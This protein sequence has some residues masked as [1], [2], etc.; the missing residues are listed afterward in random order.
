MSLSFA[1][2]TPISDVELADVSSTVTPGQRTLSF[3]I[4]TDAATGDLQGPL[5]GSNQREAFHPVPSLGG[6]SRHAPPAAASAKVYIPFHPINDMHLI[7]IV[8]A[9]NEQLAAQGE[10]IAQLKTEKASSEEQITEVQDLRM[11]VQNLSEQLASQTGVNDQLKAE[12]ASHAGAFERLDADNASH[13][14]MIK[15]LKA[16][17]STQAAAVSQIQVTNITQAGIIE[18]LNTENAALQNKVEALSEMQKLHNTTSAAQQGHLNALD[19]FVRPKFNNIGSNISS[20]RERLDGIKADLASQKDSVDDRFAGLSGTIENNAKAAGALSAS[21]LIT[22]TT[23]GDLERSSTTRFAMMQE[24]ID[25]GMNETKT[26]CKKQQSSQKI[27][28]GF[29]KSVR[30]LTTLVEE[31]QTT[32]ATN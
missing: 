25:D 12:S 30:K 20:L 21:M 26:L 2:A 16:E 1:M 18:Q 31:L 5:R 19:S 32:V 24:T 11:T 7:S 9:M 3:D 4:D 10:A 13:T 29:G 22:T 8:R 17:H 15:D 6:P 14:G 28:T 23:L 27:A